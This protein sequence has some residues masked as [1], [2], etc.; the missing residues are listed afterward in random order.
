MVNDLVMESINFLEFFLNRGHVTRLVDD[1]EIL[2][3]TVIGF[4][5][6]LVLWLG[7]IAYFVDWAFILPLI[8]I[9]TLT[10]SFRVILALYNAIAQV[11]P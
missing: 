4:L 7:Y 8:L 10:W 5:P 3:D 9:V 1:L 11:I 2:F 6:R